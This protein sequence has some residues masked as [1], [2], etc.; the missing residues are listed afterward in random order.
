DRV[1]ME[2][3]IAAGAD[4]NSRSDTNETPLH[5]AVREGNCEFVDFF[6]QNNASIDAVNDEGLTVVELA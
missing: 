6:L 2:A 5:I 4:I 3:V 1:I